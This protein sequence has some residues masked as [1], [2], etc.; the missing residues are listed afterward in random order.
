MK[1]YIVTIKPCSGFGTPIKGDTL[2]GNICWQI[3]YHEGL[4][5]TSLEKLLENYESDPF[6]VVSS[7][8]PK[9][10]DGFA[11]KKPD[12]PLD[13]LFD[14][15]NMEIA[16]RIKKRKEFKQKQWMVVSKNKPLS[17][18]KADEL[19]FN[20]KQLIDKLS[21]AKN[22]ELEQKRGKKKVESFIYNYTQSHNTI[23]RLSGTTGEGQFAP[24]EVNQFVYFPEME[25][26]IFVGLR[27]DIRIEQVVAAL[28]CVGETGFGKDASTGL[29][30]FSV[31]NY[32]ETELHSFGSQSPNALYTLAPTV[33]EKDV[34]R[35]IFFTPFTR[36]GRHGDILARSGNPFK[37][38]VI[39]AD[40]GAVL[41]PSDNNIFNKLYIG[42]AVK[43][44]SKCQPNSVVQGYSLYIPVKIEVSNE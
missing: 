37:N 3:A 2:F 14:F 12:L 41:I 32:E 16:E 31:E 11:L 4:W 30:R 38:P 22:L 29:G 7:A 42:T 39:M 20:E 18:L 26:V 43:N 9:L 10:K 1:T 5:E 35:Q 6:L 36:F 24:Y 28:K 8:Y 17:N 44:V 27:E 25:L 23:N 34:F 40:E 13:N 15:V 19:Y 21:I 33:P